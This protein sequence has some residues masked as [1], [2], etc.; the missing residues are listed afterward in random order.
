MDCS[1][2]PKTAEVLQ[3][4]DQ[5]LVKWNAANAKLEAAEQAFVKKGKKERPLAR[6]GGC[7]CCGGERLSLGHVQ[8]HRVW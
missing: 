6:V 8:G 1:V 4:V 5:L 7:C 2:W 3:P